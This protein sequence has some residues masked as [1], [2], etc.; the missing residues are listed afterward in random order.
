MA[1]LRGDGAMGRGVTSQSLVATS[2]QERQKEACLTAAATLWV[3]CGSV[4]GSAQEN[5]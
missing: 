5:A 3:A 1:K 4:M 2:A